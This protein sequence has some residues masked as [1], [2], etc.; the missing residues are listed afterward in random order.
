MKYLFALICVLLSGIATAR[1]NTL[2][3][4]DVSVAQGKSISLPVNLDNT[5]D[6]VAVQFTLAVPEGITLDVS[7]AL[8]S[9][10]SDGHVVNIQKV[11]TGKYM[12]MVFS[13]KNKS[14][15]GRT[16]KLLSITLSA[17]IDLEEGDELPLAL[18]DVVIGGRDGANLSTGFLAG[19]VTIAK[20]PDLF[21]SDVVVDRSV[22][23]PNGRVRVNWQV[24]NIGGLPTNAGWTEQILL[25]GLDGTTKLLGTVYYDG[26]LH[27]NAIVSRS[28]ELN[29]PFVIGLDGDAK[30]RV[31]LTANSNAGEPSWLLDNNVAWTETTVEVGKQLVLTPDKVGIDEKSAQIYR[32][33]LSRSGSLSSD[34]RFELKGCSDSRVSLPEFI[35]I[36][37]GQSGV[38][39]YAQTTANGLLDNDSVVDFTVSGNGYSEVASHII[40][41]DDVFPSLSVESDVQDVTEGG[42]IKMMVS[43]ERVSSKDIEVKL[44]CDFISRFEIPSDIVIPAGK[45]SVE[46]VVKAVEDEIPNME[47]V[48]TFVATAV[49]H[50][51]ASLNVLLI[52][53]DVPTLKMDLFPKAVSETSGPLAVTAKLRRVDNIDKVVTVKISDD[54]DGNI[55]YGQ[56]S[57][58]MEKGV[59]EVTVN[60]GVID[61]A[62]V[63]GERAYNISA[64]V[65]IASCGCNANNGMSGGVV[66]AP[67]TVYDD[68]GPVL[69]LTP[70]ASV[71]KENDAMNVTV[72]RNTDVL[73]ALTVHI[74][75]D[76]DADIEYPST[77]VIPAGK[78]ESTFVVT[79]K[80][81]NVSGDGFTAV[82]TV[83]ADGFA[84]GNAWFTV[85]DQTLPDVQITEI[86]TVQK[87]FETGDTVDVT[88]V[89]TNTGNAVLP[90]SVSVRIFDKGKSFAISTAYTEVPIDP[91]QSLNVCQKVVVTGE[92]GSWA[93]YA[94][95]NDNKLAQ[96]L[97]YGNNT[98]KFV[99]VDVVAPF[100]VTSKTSK[101][102]YEAGETVCISGHADG[103]NTQ[104]A[105]VEVYIINQG[106]RHVLNAVTDKDGNFSVDYI[107]FE[108]QIGHFVVGACFPG[109]K[110]SEEQCYFDIYGM[111]LADGAVITCDVLKNEIFKGSIVVSNPGVL[112]LNNV[113]AILKALPNNCEIEFSDNISTLNGGQS[114]KIGFTLKGISV[115]SELAWEKMN[116]LIS[117]DECAPIN[118]PVYYYVREPQGKLSVDVSSIN[119]SVSIGSTRDYVLTLTNIGKGETGNI[120]FSM[121]SWMKLATSADIP[122]LSEGEMASVVLTISTNEQMSANQSVTGHIGINCS[123]G[124]GISIPYNIEPVSELVGDLVLDVCDEFTYYTSEAPH[125]SNAKVQVK[126][127]VTGALVAEGVTETD[128]KY[129]I[130]LPEGYYAVSIT[131]DR[132]ESYSNNIYVNPGRQNDIT[133]NLGYTAITYNFVVEETEI[134]D[135]YKIV[136]KVVYET[137]VPLPC[138]VLGV[139]DRIDGD[140]MKAGESTLVYFTATN[141]GLVTALNVTVNIPEDT[142]E[143]KFEAL[144]S[145]EPFNLPAQQAVAIPV[146]ITRLLDDSTMEVQQ[147]IGK[148]KANIVTYFGNC[149]AVVSAD[150]EALCGDELKNNKALE[151]MAL[152]MCGA[153]A[154]GAAIYDALSSLVSASGLG[155]GFGGLGTPGGAGGNKVT[156][157]ETHH[158][159]TSEQ[160]FNMCDTCDTNRAEAM[161]DF[162]LGKTFLAPINEGMNMAAQGAQ[163]MRETK[164][165]KVRMMLTMS[166]FEKLCDYI[167][168][169]RRMRVLGEVGSEV[170]GWIDDFVEVIDIITQEC[171]VSDNTESD[172][173]GRKSSTS[174]RSWQKQYNDVARRVADYML[175]YDRLL[176]EFFGDKDWYIGDMEEKKTLFS[177]LL[178]KDDVTV[179][180]ALS[181]KPLSMTDE[182]VIAFLERI[183]NTVEGIDTDNCIHWNRVDDIVN[184][185]KVMD[186]QAVSEGYESLADQYQEAYDICMEK[187][188]EISSS[189]CASITL[190]FS[191]SMVMT[192][193]AFRGTLTVFNGHDTDAMKDV[194]LN[195]TVKNQEG[196]MVTSHEFQINPEAIDGFDGNLSLTDGWTLDAQKNGVVKVLFIPTKYAAPTVA[197]LY[198]FGGTL[199]YT[200][201]FTGLEVVRELS[202]VVLT[203]KPSPNLDFTYFM[204][205]DIKGDDPFTEEVEPSEE[206]EFSLLINN[207]G[208]GDAIHVQMVT[209]QP[210]IIENEKGLLI[211]FELISSQLN[212]REKTLALGGSVATDFGTIPAKS[213]SYAQWWLKSSLLGHF[214]DYNVEATHVTSYGNPDLSLLNEVTIHELI[215]SLEV[216]DGE[217]KIVGFMTN[218]ITD[219]EDTPDMIYFSN[220][221]IESVSVAQYATI[222]KVSETDYLLRV[223]PGNERWSY[224]NV[225]DPTYGISDLKS[226]VRQSDG[227]EISLRNFWQTDR[228][229]RDGKDPLYENRIHFADKFES[230]NEETYILTF[231][232]VPDL[233][234]E[235]A[236]IEGV[237]DEDA[238][239]VEPLESVNVVFNKSINPA[240]FTKDDLSLSVQ[241][242]KQDM[243]LVNLTTNDN[244]T[245]KVDFSALNKTV[246][247]GYFVLTVQTSDITDYEG[248]QGKNGKTTGW[249]MYRDGFVALN[250]AAYPEVAGTVQCVVK[251]SDSK[252]GTATDSDDAA[253][254]YGDVVV[255]TATSNHG[256]EFRNWTLNGEVI[257]NEP[258]FEYTAIHDMDVVA[259]Y[260]TKTY[261]VAIEDATE[262]G[263]IL[264]ASSGLY[265]FGDELKLVAEPNE[266][267][268][269]VCWT[270]NGENAGSDDALTVIVDDSLS[271]SAKF[272]RDI[273]QQDMIFAR[274][275]NWI[276]N[277]IDEQIPVSRILGNVS[278]VLG[279]SNT[280]VYDSEY[281]INDDCAALLPGFAYKVNASY[282]TMKSFKGRV[283]DVENDCI[284]LQTGWNWISYPYFE[285]R[286]T[287]V[288][289]NVEEGDCVV[290][291]TGFSE[292]ANGYWEGTLKDFVP[293]SGYLYKS[294][295]DKPLIFNFMDASVAA[296]DKAS[297]QLTNVD[298]R[299]YPSTMNMIVDLTQ[300]KTELA[301]SDCR[302][303][304]MAEDEHR[305]EAV[306]IDGLYYLT[307][308]GEEPVLISFFVEDCVSG[309]IYKA[310]ETLFFNE[311]MVGG[312]KS[313]YILTIEDDVTKIS[314]LTSDA[315]KMRVYSIEGMLLYKEATMETL[316]R[317]PRGLYIVNGQKYIAR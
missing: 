130:T 197:E 38:Y 116:I 140:N 49:K 300:L 176:L 143:W 237:P 98:S 277:Y 218:D 110:M 22:I 278:R 77:V 97:D 163:N 32:F 314:S 251:S 148:R 58:I 127:P 264:G 29:V 266:D 53:N 133:V 236:S 136:T 78:T 317:L 43:T 212:G 80:E 123:M 154:T 306:Y 81:N 270:V 173:K 204:Q 4:P 241:G 122:S 193:Q 315:S 138:V 106:Y 299:K 17:S 186:E 235:V 23:E 196:N 84:K 191:Q 230:L 30:I 147:R 2:S 85:S 57:V 192:R 18:S 152:K 66:S 33:Q 102:L 63:D 142:D 47:E 305:G 155:G 46:V 280:F 183:N 310:K 215:R 179:E 128:G 309:T 76:H 301:K 79:S 178:E 252:S 105:D 88:V 229:L 52:D 82:L 100:H 6:V 171:P 234:L 222:Q 286:A 101:T 48:V 146:R 61:N 41:E 129:R 219:A 248:Y 73:D 287:D 242:V 44:S 107:P 228:T 185:S 109:E 258:E 153:A 240:T 160:S 149:M 5:E 238:L 265:S 313:P 268:V 188:G 257:S 177:L 276:S 247:N 249:I 158:P 217:D 35:T 243:S 68:D 205:R 87:S 187:Y 232:P 9:E 289:V 159:V 303:Y 269:F 103:R 312:R 202:P 42:I 71:L 96:E 156:Y 64:A 262:E 74:S 291:Q 111:Q 198:S 51:S 246:G 67:L 261:S 304:A 93:L 274:G 112:P 15:I 297:G 62:I 117:A 290:S 3:I 302:I 282:A 121:P 227:K 295:S 285:A 184:V 151:R 294:S 45:R 7:S 203:V 283:H 211:D 296:N 166:A 92:I 39:F 12:A 267:Y 174:L 59:E 250:T 170:M 145:L 161:V 99:Y 27:P 134:E 28:V 139:P 37:K 272:K 95:V 69:A 209:E 124:S 298:M 119:A 104:N 162:F 89:L 175:N 108:N 113:K 120:M 19:K 72:V 225:A 1:N 245:F 189:V 233:Q 279:P 132:H 91:M 135:E 40:I 60:L 206:A 26:T 231:E 220:G 16:G 273:Y 200:D 25:E 137:D 24:S 181:V 281:G 190:Q 316:K 208:F 20:S 75:C 199:S 207:I 311:D 86:N 8:L 308:Y 54:S 275:W 244:K 14:F 224:G 90:A 94:A 131:A 118:V 126:H 141:K 210:E 169:Q 172:V 165:S 56:Q 36:S 83:E 150:Y 180:Q 223:V 239:V 13:S 201:P 284:M 21:V 271:I 115:S 259:N 70:S 168:E 293:G 11:G 34:E 10:R 55:Y 144:T 125:V 216:A 254:R 263:G 167:S 288:L 31:Q 194:K 221:E 256:Y 292:Y 214:T 157:G 226:V 307:V 260:S 114:A 164:E 255:L 213:T 65:W 182:Q 253:A 195:L 50:N